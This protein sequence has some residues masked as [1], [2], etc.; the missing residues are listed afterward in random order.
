MFDP[1]CVDSGTT[2]LFLVRDCGAAFLEPRSED[3]RS[4]LGEAAG[5]ESPGAL[6][7]T[8]ARHGPLICPAR[9]CAACP[10]LAGVAARCLTG[11]GLCREHNIQGG[12]AGCA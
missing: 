3:L 4:A 10:S 1:E 8:I 12:Q 5:E 9:G 6:P 2:P 7:Y 11:S